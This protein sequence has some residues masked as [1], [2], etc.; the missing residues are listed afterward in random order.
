MIQIGP[1]KKSVFEAYLWGADSSLPD[2][3]PWGRG[4]DYVDLSSRW[5]GLSGDDYE[6]SIHYRITATGELG[7]A[8]RRFFRRMRR[9][10]PTAHEEA[11]IARAMDGER[12]R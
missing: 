7:A 10:L 9:G 5:N 1:M 8:L 2:W 3:L 6:E 11:R 12:G 4:I